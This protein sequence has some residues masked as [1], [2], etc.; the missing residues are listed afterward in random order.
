MFLLLEAG[1]DASAVA[2]SMDHPLDHVDERLLASL[3]S[4]SVV[5]GYAVQIRKYTAELTIS[6]GGWTVWRWQKRPI[7][8]SGSGG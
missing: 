4:V 5:D 8:S 3:F 2:I 6:S 7:V 1:F